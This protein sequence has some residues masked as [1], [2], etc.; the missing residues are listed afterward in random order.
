VTQPPVL[1]TARLRLRPHAPSDVA[2]LHALWADPVTRTFFGIPAPSQEDAWGRMLRYAGM[3]NLF[4]FGFWAAE[5]R[6][7]GAF[8]GDFGIGNMGRSIDPPLGDDPEAGWV[9]APAAHGHGFATEAMSAVLGWA[10]ANLSHPRLSCIIHP[11]NT[12]SLRVAE[13]L[14]FQRIA[15]TQYHDKPTLILERLRPFGH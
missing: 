12:P 6:Q 1:E 9:L 7:S 3:W 5:D 15:A 13:K 14:G 4:G 8:L 2:A 10:D 11:E